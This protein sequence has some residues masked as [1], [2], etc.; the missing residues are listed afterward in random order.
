MMQA[1]STKLQ[2]Q[3]DQTDSD[4]KKMVNFQHVVPE[5]TEEQALILGD[6]VKNVTNQTADLNC[7]VKTDQ[8]RITK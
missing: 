7:V 2:I 8:V 4:K 6:I 1:L 3:L 5:V